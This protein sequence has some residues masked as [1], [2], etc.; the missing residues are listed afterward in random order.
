MKE[1]G[2][3]INN[4]RNYYGIKSTH[5]EVDVIEKVKNYKNLPKEVDLVVIR[6]SKTGEL[7]ESKP[8]FH[9]LDTMKKS[10]INI[11]NV[12]YSTASKKI[13]KQSFTELI[14]SDSYISLGQRLS[15]NIHNSL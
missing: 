13:I 14:H 1:I 9:C 15:F 5:A 11:K 3:G 8:C 6:L 2:F 10:K 7:G 4:D 12:Y